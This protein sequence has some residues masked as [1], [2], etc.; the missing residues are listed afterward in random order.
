M[1]QSPELRIVSKIDHD[2]ILHWLRDLRLKAYTPGSGYKVA[3]VF[4]MKRQNDYVLAGGVTLNVLSI[5]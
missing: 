2:E 3:A 5:A 4:A 1:P